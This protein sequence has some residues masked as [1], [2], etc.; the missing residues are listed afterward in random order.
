LRGDGGHSHDARAF[1]IDSPKIPNGT[2]YSRSS[3]KTSRSS[4]SISTSNSLVFEMFAPLVNRMAG[5]GA[6][7]IQP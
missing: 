1:R 2:T 5:S 4:A 3:A 6:S 7:G